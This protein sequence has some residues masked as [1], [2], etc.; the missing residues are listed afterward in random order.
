MPAGY[1]PGCSVP[2]TLEVEDLVGMRI[3][4]QLLENIA[5]AL[6]RHGLVDPRGKFRAARLDLGRGQQPLE[7]A[8]NAGS[9]KAARRD[10][11]AHTQTVEPSSVIGLVKCHRHDQVRHAGGQPLGQC[12]DATVMNQRR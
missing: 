2:P 11:F 3:W 10:S 12:A 1:I 8:G 6:N 9:A 5:G 7:C 4:A